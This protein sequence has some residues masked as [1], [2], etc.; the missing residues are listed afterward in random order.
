MPV[1]AGNLIS[2]IVTPA[3]AVQ[4]VL[5]YWYTPQYT[6]DFFISARVDMCHNDGCGGP[7]QKGDVSKMYGGI[8]TGCGGCLAL[9]KSWNAVRHHSRAKSNLYHNMRMM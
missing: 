9:P 6:S 5:T 7:C 4:Y 2:H 1:G 3:A 8:M